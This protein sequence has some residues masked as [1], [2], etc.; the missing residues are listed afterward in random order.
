VFVFFSCYA[1]SS[2][3]PLVSSF[4]LTLL[5]FYEFQL[6]HLSPH[7]FVLVGTDG[8][9]PMITWYCQLGLQQVTAI[10]VMRL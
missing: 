6:Q 8:R 10:T 4:L 5:E 1:T 7:S 9:T 2:L 3:V